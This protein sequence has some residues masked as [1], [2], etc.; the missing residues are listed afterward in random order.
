MHDSEEQ[1]NS[2]TKKRPKT[3]SNPF[4][5]S[6]SNN[7]QRTN[8]ESAALLRGPND[9][10]HQD[11]LKKQNNYQNRNIGNS[12]IQIGQVVKM[13]RNNTIDQKDDK[14]AQVVVAIERGRNGSQKKTVFTGQSYTPKNG[15][16]GQNEQV[17]NHNDRQ[18][19]RSSK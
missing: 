12:A 7:E 2:G 3:G 14:R 18:G 16:A 19:S 10:Q 1:P 17:N 8:P 15:V 11:E 6:I 9:S 5:P 4:R 13:N